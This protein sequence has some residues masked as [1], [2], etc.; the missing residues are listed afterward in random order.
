LD[1]FQ[2]LWMDHLKQ[3][4]QGIHKDDDSKSVED[5]DSESVEDDDSKS[6]EEKGT[7]SKCNFLQF[8]GNKKKEQKERERAR[9]V[10]VESLWPHSFSGPYYRSTANSI[11]REWRCKKCN[12]AGNVTDG[13]FPYFKSKRTVLSYEVCTKCIEEAQRESE[14]LKKDRITKRKQRREKKRRKSRN[15]GILVEVTATPPPPTLPFSILFGG[16]KSMSP[17]RTVSRVS[18][19][20]TREMREDTSVRSALCIIPPKSVWPRI[21][22]IRKQHDPA[23]VR[24]MP[25][26]NI[27]FPFIDE[28]WF[29]E[30]AEYIEHEVV[31]KNNIGSFHI[32][33]DK[34]DVF[35]RVK[36]HRGP[37]PKMETIFLQP[38]GYGATM[39]T[40]W[41][42]L[43][44]DWPIC[45][46]KHGGEF[47]PHL[48]CA[49]MKGKSLDVMRQ[50][51]N[52]DWQTISF[53]CTELCLISRRGNDP[54][55][56]RHR[57]PLNDHSDSDILSSFS[58]SDIYGRVK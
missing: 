56:V 46:G 2:T 30:I 21:Q 54:F 26:I 13:S 7:K 3:H 23:Y 19:V 12:A 9:D 31:K 18:K 15:P 52:Q 41:M 16:S 48:T 6:M 29:P 37:Y 34:F 50:K 20:L 58:D 38:S 47:H 40:L 14:N 17:K 27:F 53:E 24:W 49:K 51:W 42:H 43:S 55:V 35:D 22:D 5:D 28:K 4:H 45:G 39:Q 33:L 1:Y 36:N 32:C 25:H 8:G 10:Y 44:T 57:I 11:N